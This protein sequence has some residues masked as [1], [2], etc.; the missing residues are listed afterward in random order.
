V[1]IRQKEIKQTTL[2][3][4]CPECFSNE[5]LLLTF[6]QK[7][8]ESPWYKKATG[9]ITDSIRCQNCNTDIYPVRWTDDIERVREFYLKSIDTPARYFKLTRLAVLTLL[10]IALAAIIVYVLVN[11]TI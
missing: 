6:Y 4:N 5:G 2:T 3:N 11:N 10:A 1:K 9:E 7:H 8:I